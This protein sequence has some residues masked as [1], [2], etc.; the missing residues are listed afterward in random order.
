MPGESTYRSVPT[1]RDPE[2]GA[3]ET[4]IPGP[5]MTRHPS[6]DS[7]PSDSGSTPSDSG[8]SPSPSTPQKLLPTC[9][10]PFGPRLVRAMPSS[11]A[12]PR[13]QPEGSDHRHGNIPRLSGKFGGHGPCGHRVPVKMERIKVLTGSEVESDYK[14]PETMDTRVVMGQEALLKTMESQKKK[15]V[16][17]RS[18]QTSS[19]LGGLVLEVPKTS[20]ESQPRVTGSEKCELD[21]GQ[22]VQDLTPQIEQEKEEDRGS[23]LPSAPLLSPLLTALIPAPPPSPEPTTADLIDSQGA[24]LSPSQGEVPSLSL[25]E[26]A[27]PVALSFSEPDYPVDPLRVG[28]PSS[29]DPDLYYTAPSTPI[30]MASRSSHLKHRSYPGSPASPLSPTSPSDSEDLCSPLTSPSGSYITA[31]G[32]SWTS[33]YTS[34][35]SPSTSPNLLLAEEGQDAQEAPAC[36]V[37]SLSEIGDEVAEER[38]QGSVAKEEERGGDF[39]PFLSESF[40]MRSRLGATENVI[41]EEEEVLR[42]EVIMVSQGSCRPRWVTENSSPLRS[43]SGRSSD[44]QEEGEESEGSLCPGEEAGAGGVE[45]HKPILPRGL[46][47][48]LEACFSQDLNLQMMQL[49]GKD[50]ED[51]PELSSSPVTPHMASSSLFP[52]FPGLPLEAYTSEGLDGESPGPFLL[53]P[54]AYSHDGPEDERMI[55]ASLL[56]FPLHTSFIFQADSMEITLFPT[57]DE[58]KGGEGNSRNE[59]NDVDAYAAGEEEGDVEDDDDDE[60]DKNDDGD[61]GG[62]EI[63]VGKEAKV[64]VAVKEEEEEEDEE[65]CEGKLVEDPTEEDTSASFL[66][67]L[68]E[69]SINEGLDESFCFHDETDDSLD[70]ASYNGEEDERLYS[71]ERHAESLEPQG[72]D[73]LDPTEPQPQLRPPSPAREAEVPR[74]QPEGNSPPDPSPVE[75]PP[76]CPESSNSSSS[77][78][79]EMEISSSSSNPP[80]PSV[81]LKSAV[82]PT[83]TPGPVG[84]VTDSMLI[85]AIA[86]APVP[87]PVPDT[88][89]STDTIPALAIYTTPDPATDT[90]FAPATD[91]NP[92]LATDTN[93]APATDT[94]PA[95]A[96]DTTH[97]PATD[98]TPA[99]AT[100]TTPVPATEPKLATTELEEEKLFQSSMKSQ[101][102]KQ[103]TD[104]QEEELTNRTEG[105]SFT[106]LI[107]PRPS[108]SHTPRH[109]GGRKQFKVTPGPQK[110]AV[111]GFAVAMGGSGRKEDTEKELDQK[112][113]NTPTESQNPEGTFSSVSQEETTATNDL[114]KGVPL[115]SYPKDPTSNSSNIPVSTYPE[116]LT[117]LPDNLGLTPDLCP[118]DLAQEN[119]RENTLSAEEGGPGALGS[120]HSPMA[121]SPKRENSETDAGG[122]IGLGAA[123]W[124]SDGMG[125]GLDLEL[126][127]GLRSGASVGAWGAGESLSLSLGEGY[128]LDAESVLLCEMDGQS[129]HTPVAPNIS[130]QGNNEDDVLGDEEDNNSLCGR[131]DKMA[132]VELAGEGLESN[133][134]LWSSIEEISEAGGGE[135]GSSRFPEDDVSNLQTLDHEG[136]NTDTQPLWKKSA[137]HDSIFY[138]LAKPPCVTLNAL[139]EKARPQSATVRESISN[140]P[141]TE[142]QSPLPDQPRTPTRS[143]TLQSETTQASPSAESSSSISLPEVETQKDTSMSRLIGSDITLSLLGGSFGSFNPRTRHSDSRPSKGALEKALPTVK[144][145]E[146]NAKIQQQQE[147]EGLQTEGLIE[148]RISGVTD[149]GMDQTKTSKGAF[150]GQDSGVSTSGGKEEEERGTE[151]RMEG[152]KE[153]GLEGGEMTVKRNVSP[154]EREV[155]QSERCTPEG[156][157]S[158]DKPVSA[159]TG[160][161]GKDGRARGRERAA[162]LDWP[163]QTSPGSADELKELS[164]PNKA[165]ADGTLAAGK[166]F[167]KATAKRGK[168]ALREPGPSQFQPRT[169]VDYPE[170]ESEITEDSQPGSGGHSA[171]AD[172]YFPDLYPSPKSN[173]NLK[174]ANPA[175]VKCNAAVFLK[176]EVLDNR[177]ISDSQTGSKDI[178]DNNFGSGHISFPQLSTASFPPSHSPPPPLPVCPPPTSSPLVS[179]SSPSCSSSPPPLSSSPLPLSSSPI[180]TSTHSPSSSPP[181]L[182]SSPPPL[183]S[184]PLS[185]SP[186]PSPQKGT[187]VTVPFL[188]QESQPLH[189]SS[190]PP[191]PPS[192]DAIHLPAPPTSL[193]E[194]SLPDTHLNSCTNIQGQQGITDL[195]TPSSASPIPTTPTRSVS[196]PLAPPLAPSSLTQPTQ[197]HRVPNT[198]PDL[199]PQPHTFLQPLPMPQLE[200]HRQT[201]P[202]QS[203]SL[204]ERP[205]VEEVTDSEDDSAAQRQGHRT[206]PRA[207]LGNRGSSYLNKESGSSNQRESQPSISHPLAD[208]QAGCSIS[209]SYKISEEIDLSFKNNLGSCN[210]SESEGSV[211][212]REEPGWTPVRPSEPQSMSAAEEAMNRPKQSRSEKKARKAM[213]KLGLKPVHGIT[214]IT[215]RKSK[216]ILFVIS[217]PDVFKSPA[218]DIYIVFGEAKIEDLSQQVHKA[219]AEK[220]K[221]PVAP[222][223][224]APPAPPSLT[225]K[226]ESEEEEEDEG[227][228]EQ[229]DIELVMAQANVS[230]AKAV[231]ALKHNKNDIVNA[232]MELTM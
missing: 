17:G 209:H 216:S 212:E 119:L 56:S 1:A 55:P 218:S 120:P 61:K 229:R 145:K 12:T 97:A 166:A 196:L 33:S 53:F 94:T 149:R 176:Q 25:S 117:D 169:S 64:E 14:E 195:S 162:Q 45:Y 69:T 148:G 146:E 159:Q 139:S 59:G 208:R 152:G 138:P 197:E 93:S 70:S 38:G 155:E 144:D 213:S 202:G 62:A 126:G 160:R 174:L 130:T 187:E 75:P 102:D 3:E 74:S 106:L 150:Q 29:L 26:L 2:R 37:G 27:Y 178:H 41:L 173:P 71:T 5:D 206:Q 79:S 92:A 219:A 161:R 96:T 192:T 198:V 4:G 141:L 225:I 115:L 227:A 57:E 84:P 95:P 28:V 100:D 9:T 108:Q 67:S 143:S 124:G 76:A 151:T 154:T 201:K 81:L 107:K 137:N 220:F 99:P 129:G 20:S 15:H 66:H 116:G 86:A 203:W 78:E 135:D 6:T 65:E 35:T 30:K 134:S 194:S 72:P 51:L 60:D 167:Y 157:L 224:L 24:G 31:E 80:V 21:T 91:T 13:P 221:V 199:D 131:P 7:T 82:T 170:A 34:S 191:A 103:S 156:E 186:P 47:L 132:D 11:S 49:V 147:E 215:I 153:R 168:K 90:T 180:S 88:T 18:S 121:I 58:N 205:R 189:P 83:F 46:E 181:L 179:S 113:G 123:S 183:S 217:R 50:G 44:S 63:E 133:L 175:P 172:D 158:T 190:P 125:L 68:S 210:E 140:I 226:E 184:S 87:T 48:E 211:P 16:A 73:L 110:L 177:A 54:G 188:V 42:G 182:P 232:I 8:S 142:E 231:K 105:D 77:S 193:S 112:N 163:A 36:F 104:I 127:R 230:R 101:R 228:L 165:E 43:S 171:G 32:G 214:R 89:P 22:G 185:S 222:S 52:D 98:T 200:S 19:M 109:V 128:E 10:S 114:N 111:C 85:C 204:E 40:G 223:P 23:V 39:R 164:V 136:D 118:C 207:I 122:K